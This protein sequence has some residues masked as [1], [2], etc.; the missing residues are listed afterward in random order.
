[1]AI[2]NRPLKNYLK[3]VYSLD[4]NIRHWLIAWF[5]GIGFAFFG[6]YMVV[7]N[8]YVTRLGFGTSEVGL[9]LSIQTITTA[10]TSLPAGMLSS[11][12]STRKL[13]FTGF[14][15]L[16]GSYLPVILAPELP[17]NGIMPTLTAGMIVMGIGTAFVLTNAVPLFTSFTDSGQ[18]PMAF[19]LLVA[20]EP[21]GGF[22]GSLAGGFLPEIIS[23][24][25]GYSMSEAAPYRLTLLLPMMILAG[26]AT[27]IKRTSAIPAEDG[28]DDS[29]VTADDRSGGH[30]KSEYRKYGNT[31]PLV[32]ILV[33]C[34][35]SATRM[36]ATFFPRMF[37]NIYIESIIG[38]G[39]SSIGFALGIAQLA[40][41]PV[42]LMT[43]VLYSYMGKERTFVTG[44]TVSVGGTM[45]L[46]FVPTF[47]FAAIAIVI[48]NLGFGMSNA[49]FNQYTQE[50]VKPKFRAPVFGAVILA[51]SIG[52][53][54]M[55]LA[56]GKLIPLLGYNQV[57]LISGIVSLA[58]A[59][60]FGVYFRKPRG[61]YSV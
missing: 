30:S 35:V 14:L 6:I 55:N 36:Q 15:I 37:F 10:L 45:I 7:F 39:V 50:I 25:L 40:M 19:A 5:A 28:G 53:S 51:Q 32:I 44:I 18:R 38:T 60:I 29:A 47:P 41:I 3:S 54:A 24:V 1:M 9:L 33:L 4:R 56:G 42:V 43:P 23:S 34:F 26:A 59:L 13:T 49:V 52:I 20:V 31:I 8:L 27:A 61:E 11:R 17:D 46:A 2:Q 16:A 58:A 12:Y 57:F 48:I 22:F 21:L